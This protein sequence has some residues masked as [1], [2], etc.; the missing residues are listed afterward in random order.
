VGAAPGR[1]VR[2]RPGAG[3]G[4]RR[5]RGRRARPRRVSVCPSARGPH[6]RPGQHGEPRSGVRLGGAGAGAVGRVRRDARRER[7]AR[8]VGVGEG[9]E[10]VP[11]TPPTSSCAP[12]RTGSPGSRRTCPPTCASSPA[13]ASRT[14][15]VSGRRRRPS[16]RASLR[17][18]CSR[19]V[20]RWAGRA[21]DARRR[22][23]RRGD[24]PVDRARGPPR[25]RLG[26]RPRRDD[27]VVDPGPGR[28]V[29]VGDRHRVGA[30]ASRRHGGRARAPRAAG[31]AYRRAVLPRTS[32]TSTPPS[33]R[34]RAR[35]SSRR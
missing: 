6:P 11:R 8:G 26:E 3:S 34:A 33:T 15:G 23:P 14:A 5:D 7:R 35:C 29:A 22:R 24:R 30:T 21:G 25:Q 2:G 18:R 32:T 16:S 19:I 1:R 28:P 20:E 4:R 12:W 13:T 10:D 27:G 9:R 31:D 17:R